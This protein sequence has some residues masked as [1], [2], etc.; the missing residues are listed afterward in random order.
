MNRRMLI[1]G[2]GTVLTAGLAGCAQSDDGSDDSDGGADHG[3]GDND[4]GNGGDNDLATPSADPQSVAANL[5][6][7][8]SPTAVN[9]YLHPDTD[10]RF[11]DFADPSVIT[12][13]DTEIEDQ[14]DEDVLIVVTL[15]LDGDEGTDDIMVHLRA[16]GGEW[17]YFYVLPVFMME[18]YDMEAGQPHREGESLN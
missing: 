2:G 3:N 6:E 9:D 8:D 7:F 16:D 15:Q 14:T 17:R 18:D 13:V 5:D 10:F 11:D 12:V 1:I 4:N